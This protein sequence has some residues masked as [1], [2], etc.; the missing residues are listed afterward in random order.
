MSVSLSQRV[1]A[2]GTKGAVVWSLN[3]NVSARALSLPTSARIPLG[4]GAKSFKTR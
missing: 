2:D 4:R 3:A 1:E